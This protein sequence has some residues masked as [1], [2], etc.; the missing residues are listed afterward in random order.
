M[1]QERVTE[2]PFSEMGTTPEMGTAIMNHLGLEAYELNNHKTF[3]ML[4]DVVGY[5]GQYDKNSVDVMVR[6][7]TAGAPKEE[8]LDR[9]FE[10]VHTR[11]ELDSER[12]GFEEMQAEYE[13]KA[14]RIK[15]LEETLKRIER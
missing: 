1:D 7:I 4:S 14:G 9:L 10:F 15:L 3:G 13:R 6:R 11:K 5:L 8:R 2:T 12:E